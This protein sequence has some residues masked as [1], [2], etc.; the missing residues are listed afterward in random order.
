MNKARVRKKGIDYKKIKWMI[1]VVEQ[2]GLAEL[3]IEEDGVGITVKA[4]SGL[5]ESAPVVSMPAVQVD[6][7]QADS[8]TVLQTSQ[9]EAAEEVLPKHLVKITSPMI[10]VFYRRP[11][12]DSPSFVEVGDM[13]EE[14]QTIGLI[15]AMKVFSEVPS[16]VAGRVV[17]IPVEN[18]KL[19][20]AED[21]LVVVDISAEGL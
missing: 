5:S 11:S 4:E 14:G 12:P 19:V 21:V 18:A 7:V 1:S 2:N 8:A 13:I 20:Q 17:D 15:E 10:G 6:E 3:T 9:P 16:E